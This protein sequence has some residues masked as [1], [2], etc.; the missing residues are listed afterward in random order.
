MVSQV[1]QSETWPGLGINLGFR[2][3]VGSIDFM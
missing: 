3:H 1:P 2:V